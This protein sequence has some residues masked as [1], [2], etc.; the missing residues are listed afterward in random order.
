MEINKE[1]IAK[2][3]KNKRQESNL[4]QIELAEKIGISEK[5]MS[6][7]ETGKNY[8]ALDTFLKILDTLNLTLGDFGLQKIDNDYP[9]KVLLQKII[10]TSSK[11]QLDA[12]AE[13]IVALMKHI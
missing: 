3:I 11:K 10:N 5:H 9:K 1:T 8:P 13:V 2:V 7:I 6:K 12:Y 4:T